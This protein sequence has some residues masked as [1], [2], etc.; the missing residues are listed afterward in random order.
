M[1]EPELVSAPIMYLHC[2]RDHSYAP[3]PVIPQLPVAACSVR[4]RRQWRWCV[5]AAI[6]MAGS[7]QRSAAQSL[8]DLDMGP[9]E[10]VF[11]DAKPT[12]LVTMHN[13]GAKPLNIWFN[14][15]CGASQD[16]AEHGDPIADAWHNQSSCAAPWLS[17]YPQHVV[18]APKERRTVSM[19]MTPPPTLPD[20]HYTARLIWAM[21]VVMTYNGQTVDGSGHD[22]FSVTYDKG[23][24]PPRRARMQWRATLPAGRAVSLVGHTPAVLVL[25]DDSTPTT[26]FTL[27]NPGATPTEV[28]LAVDC[29]WFRVNFVPYPTS[30]QYESA[31][32]GRIPS[33]AFWLSGYPQHL[34]LAPHE[35][36]TISIQAFPQLI[37]GPQPAGS[38]YAQ[39]TYV[40]SPVLAVTAEGDTT[41]STPRGVIN[42]V[43]HKY[44]KE[45]KPPSPLTLS[46]LQ[47]TSHPDGTS[48]ACVTV[49]QP[50]LGVVA[51]LHAEVD[52]AHG[53]R[54]RPRPLT[55]SAG[56]GQPP[57]WGIDTTVAVWEVVHHNP[58]DADADDAPKASDPVCFAL[59]GFAPGHYQL[60]VSAVALED[61]AK[62]H[63]VRATL[64]LEVP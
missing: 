36:R 63:P 46:Q 27:H 20:G 5:A 33:A 25:E 2:Q 21:Y 64:P 12:V 13:S 35:R 9:A 22:E 39:L 43:Y 10:L 53:H 6:L 38:Y 61:I 11:S 62:H 50:G 14:Q 34:V 7:A 59:P 19:R 30:H 31:W 52:D 48:R 51:V 49:Q 57:A 47:R 55:G 8:D 56:G 29:P 26:T 60:V 42:V 18:L 54:V 58:L 1:G 28:W 45:G 40:Q 3:G 4:A 15:A 24:K 32:H 17:G 44:D 37:A 16:S 41:Y 23:P